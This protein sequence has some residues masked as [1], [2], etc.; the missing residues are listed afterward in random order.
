MDAFDFDNL[1]TVKANAL[2]R[3][4]RLQNVAKLIRLLELCAALI[5]LSWTSSRLPFLLTISGDYLQL[6]KLIILNPLFIFLLGNVIVLTL[7]A[8]SGQLITG[9]S[10]AV[11]KSETNHYLEFTKNIENRIKLES[12]NC[13]S[14]PEPEEI[15]YQDKQIITV[16]SARNHNTNELTLVTDQIVFRRS[17]SETLSNNIENSEKPCGKLQRSETEIC[18]DFASSGGSSVELVDELSNEEFQRTIEAFIAKQLRSHK[19]EKVVMQN[20]ISRI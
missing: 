3:F 2:L 8:N 19:K 15:V 1:K 18:R 17:Q 20:A 16:T 6:L 7:L 12:D 11:I 14:V 9:Q 10:S 4:R 13:H 5:F